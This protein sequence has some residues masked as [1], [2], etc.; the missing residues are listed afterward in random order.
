VLVFLVAHP[1]KMQKGEVPTL[2]DISG[3]ANFYNKTDYGFTVHRKRNDKTNL[4]INE[5]EVYWQKI[6]FKNLGEQGVSELKY[7]Y[8]NGRFEHINDDVDHWD[9]SNWLYKEKQKEVKETNFWNEIAENKDF[10]KE[11]KF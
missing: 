5:V 1:R 11:L 9:N 7:N 8:N 2:Y 6:K 3:S 10:E 4:M